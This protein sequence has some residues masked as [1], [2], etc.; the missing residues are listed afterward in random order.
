[1]KRVVIVAAAVL[2]VFAVSG[3]AAAQYPPVGPRLGPAANPPFS[4][5]LNLTRPGG[6]P[7]LN[8]YGLVRP[9][10]QARTAIQG[11][12]QQTL[13]NRALINNLA[14]PNDTGTGLPET[15]HPAA[16]M[17]T[18][19][20]FMNLSPAGNVRPTNAGAAG[21]APAGRTAPARGR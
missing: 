13:A 10:L 12:Q 20:Y 9:E 17:N 6:S 2:G 19:G 16:F 7:T 18:M 15:G 14:N 1:M 5:Y 11:L 3:R 4:P 8:Y 21:R